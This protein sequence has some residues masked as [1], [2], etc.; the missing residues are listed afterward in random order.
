MDA[1]SLPARREYYRPARARA[2]RRN[3]APLRDWVE[4]I[5]KAAE[6]ALVILFY[7]ACGAGGLLLTMARL[8]DSAVLVTLRI[9]GVVAAMVLG[10]ALLAAAV[11]P[12][13]AWK[14]RRME[15]EAARLKGEHVSRHE[16]R[17]VY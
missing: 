16:V 7:G 9:L 5:D 15:Q 14:V 2:L 1:R 17:I 11:R 10:S 6:N 12:L 13:L 8:G 3:A 4:L